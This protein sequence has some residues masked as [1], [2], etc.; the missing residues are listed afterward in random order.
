ML[1]I[2]G[3]PYQVVRLSVRGLSQNDQKCYTNQNVTGARFSLVN[4]L[5]GRHSRLNIQIVRR[6]PGGHMTRIVKDLGENTCNS[7]FRATSVL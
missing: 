7:Y 6:T 3:T 5:V 1:V 2:F 4:V